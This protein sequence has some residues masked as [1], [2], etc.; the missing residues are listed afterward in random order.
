MRKSIFF[1]LKTAFNSLNAGTRTH[2]LAHTYS[3]D[4]GER[5]KR[6]EARGFPEKHSKKQKRKR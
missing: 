4:E 6:K 5:E 2:I 3:R 1:S